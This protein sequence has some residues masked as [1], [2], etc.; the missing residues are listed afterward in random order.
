MIV[1]INKTYNA[2]LILNTKSIRLLQFLWA[3]FSIYLVFSK[4]VKKKPKI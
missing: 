4:V 2:K 3:N 1:L